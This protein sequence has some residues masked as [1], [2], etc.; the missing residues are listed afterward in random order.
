MAHTPGPWER[1]GWL[2][3]DSQHRLIADLRPK[4]P[5]SAFE[6]WLSNY[7]VTVAEIEANATLL[8]AANDLLAA[9]EAIYAE[10]GTGGDL[11]YHLRQKGYA[12]MLCAA[13]TKAKGEG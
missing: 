6:G 10:V 7:S 1:W 11:D 12:E 8:Y 4:H 3:V 2:I 9:C 13:I 5:T